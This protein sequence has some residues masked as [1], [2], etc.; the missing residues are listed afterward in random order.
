MSQH[1]KGSLNVL[2]SVNA[3]RVN[4]GVAQVSAAQSLSLNS[5][6]EIV[7]DGLSAN[8]TQALPISGILAGWS[9]LI[10]NQ[11]STYDVDVQVDGQSLAT[12]AAGRRAEFVAKIAAPAVLANWYVRDV[13]ADASDIAYDNSSSGLTAT[14]VQAA[15]DEVEDRLDTAESNWNC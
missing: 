10:D 3:L 4:R 15:I 2:A 11:D 8:V 7:F 1:I 14:D 13:A 6:S 9:I 12:V 5:S